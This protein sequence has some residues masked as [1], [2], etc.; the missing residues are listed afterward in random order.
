MLILSFF[1]HKF[2]PTIFRRTVAL[3]FALCSES[4]HHRGSRSSILLHVLRGARKSLVRVVEREAA[5]QW[6]PFFVNF[7]APSANFTVYFKLGRTALTPG[8]S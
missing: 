2:R 4:F 3:W 8:L 7:M 5:V 1:M 6:L